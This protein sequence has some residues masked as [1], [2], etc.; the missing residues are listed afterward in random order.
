[1]NCFGRSS[2]VCDPELQKKIDNA[3]GTPG[4]PER[5]RLMEEVANIAYQEVYFIPIF[6]VLMAYGLSKDV[7]WEPYYAPRLRGNTMK[8]AR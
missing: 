5:T 1:L 6:E 4:G 7:V 8:W 2:R 3:S